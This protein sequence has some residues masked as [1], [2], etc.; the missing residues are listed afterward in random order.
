MGY[1]MTKLVKMSQLKDSNLGRPLVVLGGG[2]SLPE[3]CARLGWS[4]SGGR[5]DSL[6]IAV[7]YH[8]LRLPNCSPDF[9]VFNDDPESDPRLLEAVKSF[10]GVLVSQDQRYSDVEFDVPVWTGHY[11]SNTAAWLALWM[12][13][14]PVILCGHDLYQGERVYFHDYSHDAPCFHYPLEDHLRPWVEE[15]RH[16]LPHVERLRAMSGPLTK[17]FGVYEPNPLQGAPGGA[18]KDAEAASLEEREVREA[19]GEKV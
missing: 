7:N 11:S 13:A 5:I 4:P 1:V 18:S 15:G 14:D 3:D 9:M 10:H 19:S 6:L 8:A 2:P 16:R 12:G 17:I